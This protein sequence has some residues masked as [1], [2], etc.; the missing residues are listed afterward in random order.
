[1]VKK[2]GEERSK[3]DNDDGGDGVRKIMKEVIKRKEVTLVR[4]IGAV[5]V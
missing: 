3:Q 2:N 5:L 1:V 4:E